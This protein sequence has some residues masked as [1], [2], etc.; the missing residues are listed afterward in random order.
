MS[1]WKI[2]NLLF[3]ISYIEIFRYNK[4]DLIL[5]LM[6]QIS[7]TGWLS[8]GAWKS[9]CILKVSDQTENSPSSTLAVLYWPISTSIPSFIC[10]AILQQWPAVKI[11]SSPRIVPPHVIWLS[12]ESRTLTK[13]HYNPE[14]CQEL[15]P[16]SSLK[17][18][19]DNT[20]TLSCQYKFLKDTFFYPN[21]RLILTLPSPYPS[22]FK[23]SFQ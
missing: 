22:D 19:T 23:I 21:F 5:T 12:F 11:C 14:R 8:T 3:C 13:I 17:F 2:K 1:F 10:S 7:L 16:F 9:L 18:F 15:E 20:W 4:S 6:T